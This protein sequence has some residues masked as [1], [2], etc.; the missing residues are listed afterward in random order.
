MEVEEIGV[1]VTVSAVNVGVVVVV[2]VV[3]VVVVVVGVVGAKKGVVEPIGCG[4]ERMLVLVLV[5]IGSRFG[6][7]VG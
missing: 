4:L 1:A 5:W 2:N 7:R 3:I 6:V